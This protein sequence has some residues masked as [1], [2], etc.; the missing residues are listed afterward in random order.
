M[1][2]TMLLTIVTLIF[3]AFAAQPALADRVKFGGDLDVPTSTEQ[4]DAK[5]APDAKDEPPIPEE[6]EDEEEEEPPEFMDEELEGHTFVLVLDRSGSMCSNFSGGF[7]VMD[8][9]GNVIPYP[10]RWQAVQSEAC[11]CIMA[12]TEE[13][14]FDLITFNSNTYICFSVLKEANMANKGSGIGWMYNINA[15][16][17]TR[18]YGPLNA[19]YTS[20]GPVDTILFLTDGCPADGNQALQGLRTW[21]QIQIGYNSAHKLKAIQIGGSPMSI[22]VTIG[23]LPNAEFTLK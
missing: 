11:S 20:Y 6:P 17:G 14:S 10:N 9:N 22:M 18:F 16:G 23:G 7:P 13:D 21:L 12:M 3:F 19:A 4:A 5:E 1:K 2:N 8:G 15:G